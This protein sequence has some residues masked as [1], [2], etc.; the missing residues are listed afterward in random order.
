M[1]LQKANLYKNSLVRFLLIV[2][3]AVHGLLHLIGFFKEFNLSMA[4]GFSGEHITP[5]SQP[6]SFITG[7]LWMLVC[8]SFLTAATGLLTHSQWWWLAALLA[9]LL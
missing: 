3:L 8:I 6:V 4:G 1:V 9:V 2:L 5:L 7:M